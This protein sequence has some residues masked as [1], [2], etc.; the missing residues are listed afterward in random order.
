MSDTLA[1]AVAAAQTACAM[2]VARYGHLAD[3]RAHRA[4]ADL[5]APEGEWIR[6]GMHLRG[7][8]EIFRFM[9]SRPPQ[10]LTRHVV[11][12][13]DVE[14]LDPL[15]ARGSSCTTVYREPHFRGTLPVPLRQPEMVVDYADDFVC[16]EGRWLIGDSGL[17]PQFSNFRA[18]FSMVVVQRLYS[19]SICARN[20]SGVFDRP[21]ST[22]AVVRRC[23]TSGSF[24]AAMMAWAIA[25]TYWRGVPVFMNTP[26]HEVR[27]T[28]G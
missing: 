14:V 26:H 20:W 27:S 9:E 10:A 2:L 7:R 6:P 22:P 17:E 24:D 11:G 1:T 8:E 16:I 15:H 21:M 4:F 18:A 3:R 23:T 13:I 28:P 25:S 5:F 19:A 12:S